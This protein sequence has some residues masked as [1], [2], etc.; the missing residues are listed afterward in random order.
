ME[1]DFTK[2]FEKG[3]SKLEIS[4]DAEGI[5][6]LEVY[7]K[8]LKKWNRKV[9]L[10]AKST[11]DLQIVENHFLDCLLL[12]PFLN[13]ADTHLV[14]IGTGAG[15]P[16][17]V[18][19]ASRPALEVSL[20]EPRLKRVSFL[21]H[22]QRTLLLGK[23]NIYPARIEQEAGLTGDKTIT[24]VVSRAVNDIGAFLQL[25]EGFG[26]L[27]VRVLMMKGP[28]WEEELRIAG[29]ILEFSSFRLTDTVECQLPFSRAKR[30]IL[31]FDVK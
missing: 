27:G 24:H 14:D 26:H 11:G 6:R 13:G 12:L 21:R 20:V 4:L 10:I 31:L 25:V 28:K 19:K 18:V 30:Y 9:N 1:F 22:V 3:L 29:D 15:F 23:V 5:E 8:E 2:Q 17:L 16:G 7:F